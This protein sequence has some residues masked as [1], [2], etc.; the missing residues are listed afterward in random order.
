MKKQRP[1]CR[2][3]K[4]LCFT[5]IELLVVIAIIAILAGM[6]LPALNNAR[7]KGR[8]SVCQN[9]LNTIGKAMAM[10]SDESDGWI[11]RALPPN[12]S[13]SQDQWH[14]VLSGVDSSGVK[15][16]R[17]PGYGCTFY[18]E[19][20]AKGTFY[21]PSANPKYTYR[22]GTY[23]YNRYLLGDDNSGNFFARKTSCVTQPTITF[24]SSDHVHTGVPTMHDAGSVAYRHGPGNDPGDGT[25][26]IGSGHNVKLG[27]ASLNGATY[28]VTGS[29]NVLYFDGHVSSLNIPQVMAFDGGAYNNK[30]L[31]SGYDMD[32]KSPT[33]KKN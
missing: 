29:A 1:A 30:L 8:S 15:S 6:L 23:G 12:Y 2:R 22:S 7:E 31:K 4:H 10:Y 5:L 20:H 3:V 25:R 14:M 18:G 32:Q 33:W 17:Y 16:T 28:Q 27:T 13:D 19:D 24:V 11:L 26:G 9:N 21:C